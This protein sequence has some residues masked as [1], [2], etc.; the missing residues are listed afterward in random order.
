MSYRPIHVYKASAGSGKTFAL[1]AEFIANL[2]ND[3]ERGEYPH[4]HQLAIT[5]TKKATAEMKERILQSLYDLWQGKSAHDGFFR[6]VRAQVPQHITD[7]MLR[8]RAGQTLREIVH[9]YEQFHV[10][11]IDSFFQRLL[12][13]LAHELGL[14]SSFKVDLGDGNVLGK[15]VDSLMQGLKPGSEVLEW[16]TQY[17]AEQLDEG[18][19]WNV[20]QQLKKLAQ[21]LLK[22]PYLKYGDLLRA[23]PLDN[24]TVRQYRRSMSQLRKDYLERLSTEAQMAKDFV[25]Q[26]EGF[27][28]LSYGKNILARLDR[29][30]AQEVGKD[31]SDTYQKQLKAPEALIKAADRKKHPELCAWAEEVHQRLTKVEH[32]YDH[33]LPD[34]ISCLLSVQHLNA[35]RLLDDIDKHVRL[36]NTENN[37]FMLAHTPLLFAQLVSGAEASFVFERAG[38]QYRHIMVDEFQD[39][40][41][42]QWNNLQHLLVENIAQGNSCMLVGD[43]KQGIY[44]W[45]GGDWTALSQM[46]ASE[47]IEVCTLD[48][49]YRSGECIVEFNN[50][51]FVHLA[52][53]IASE[54]RE[55]LDT[56]SSVS[57]TDIYRPDEVKQRPVLP[58]GFV[59]V[60]LLKRSNE[61][62][63]KSKEEEEDIIVADLGEHILRLYEKGVPYEK[64]AILVRK[65][66]EVKHV[67]DYFEQDATLRQ[68]PLV[69][70]EAFL[71]SSSP[72]VQTIVHALRYIHRTDD[73]VAK[74]YLIAH[75]P[76]GK[77]E[78]LLPI[79][80]QWHAQRF[81][82]LPFYELV[83]QLVR[84]FELDAQS[85][86]SPYIYA[87]L[88]NV[89]AFLEDHAPDIR[90]FLN[91]WEERLHKKSIP[92]TV[93]KGVRILT[94]HKSKGLAFH[95][96]FI[97][98]CNWTLE[99]SIDNLLWVNPPESPYNA[100]PFLPIS[101]TKLAQD[102]VYRADYE[103]EHRNRRIENLNLLYVA[104]TR[105]RQ[106]LVIC[107]QEILNDTTMYNLLA[108]VLGS[109]ESPFF[110]EM[111]QLVDEPSY[112]EFDQEKK[113]VEWGTPSTYECAIEA[114]GEAPK[115]SNPLIIEAQNEALDF[116]LQANRAK[117]RQSNKAKAMLASLDE[118]QEANNFDLAQYRA[119]RVGV[120][121][122]SLMERIETLA[123]VERVLQ[124]AR[125]EGDLAES[126]PAEEVVQLLHR[127][128]AHPIAR[129]WFDGSWRLYRECSI[130][131]RQADGKLVGQRPDRVMMRGEEVVVVDYK[132]GRA[133]SVYRQQV[134]D[135]CRLLHQMGH[136]HVQGYIWYVYAGELEAVECE[137]P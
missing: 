92:S 93:V 122:H 118:E 95:S 27:A 11:T 12:T 110:V 129:Q 134:R 66:S 130:L 51:L 32:T 107:S 127:A 43:V 67:F 2:I 62:N 76:A 137:I 48:A 80:E 26:T 90:S 99:K 70:D 87:L 37:A 49:N 114:A 59:R 3:Y 61:N 30:I 106:N 79:L 104:F 81:H 113:V 38:T 124:E 19:S 54:P 136:R 96:V 125:F 63:T 28:S 44:R 21:E 94:I 83:V 6:A 39:T 64:M 1:A 20:T 34:V 77:T 8:Q 9:N 115:S 85:G 72:A 97:P 128:L 103:E 98:Y 117:F 73:G 101:C 88:D 112:I 17:I 15:A 56:Q 5:F 100:I 33:I 52:Q 24:A 126:L 50:T 68:I 53:H 69:S 57:I 105:A 75:A 36:L 45:R 119:R 120:A 10:T 46:K 16:I 41:T 132:F 22:E 135:Y 58:G 116:R 82:S 23:L 25:E 7:G 111:S 78:S 74:A 40:S 84:L 31:R 109:P 65:N 42:L 4:R 121:L 91:E 35:L 60:H 131:Q 102:S 86:Q 89:L 18:K 47:S 14:T 29:H 55:Q 71:L 123:D 108:G 13:S 133:R